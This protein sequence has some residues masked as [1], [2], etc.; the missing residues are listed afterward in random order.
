[1]P[2]ALGGG[3][4]V[5]PATIIDGN[6]QVISNEQPTMLEKGKAKLDQAAAVARE[7]YRETAPEVLGGRTY[8]PEE[9]E[10]GT[11]PTAID[12]VQ[13]KARE[14]M[15]KGKEKVSEKL[16][17]PGQ[18]AMIQDER[19]IIPGE[20]T[21]RIAS[22]RL[23]EVRP[24]DKPFVTES[25]TVQP[26]G[27]SL[28]EKAKALYKEVAPEALGGRTP[29]LMERVHQ[30]YKPGTTEED[31]SMI[32]K[33]KALAAETLPESLGGRPPTLGERLKEEPTVL[34][35]AKVLKEETLPEA[36]GG[37]PA[38]WHEQK[39]TPEPM[40]EGDSLLAKAKKVY[41]E[42]APEALGGR[43][44]TVTE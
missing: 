2:E 41:T 15:E 8:T 31:T 36:L 14:M 9:K 12:M 33:M 26:T 44:P 22:E 42:T 24:V 29:T 39:G 23:L 30:G 32:G 28:T 13:L 5:K 7:T 16:G 4:P 11:G 34:G 27:T 38:T 1:M 6:G 3:Y 43:P 40:R 37:R 20:A 35:K 18:H 10:A 17:Y 25:E 21:T 19:T